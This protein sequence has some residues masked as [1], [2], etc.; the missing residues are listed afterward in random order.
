MWGAEIVPAQANSP[1]AAQGPQ[2][3]HAVARIKFRGS[4]S[5]HDF[6]GQVNSQ[7]FVL[8]LSSNT[9][10]AESDA[11]AG[12]VTTAN[13]RRD[14]NMWKMFSTNLYPKLWGGVT[15][16]PRPENGSGKAT[17][18]LQIRN[19]RASWPVTITGWK[20]TAD[21]VRFH[22]EWEVSL[23]R[24]DLKPPSVLGVIQVGDVVRLAADVK[25]TKNPPADHT[26][27][28]TNSATASKF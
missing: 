2:P 13:A 12:E 27:G 6:A 1:M 15:N 5:L 20:E 10:S 4:S 18:G 16:A 14:R 25:A 24:Y 22:A 23:K 26:S 8:M 19:L 17:L 21:E 11:I 3:F 9:W 7:P 28:T